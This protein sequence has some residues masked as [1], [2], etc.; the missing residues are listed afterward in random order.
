[1]AGFRNI[2]KSISKGYLRAI[3]S[4]VKLVI[5]AAAISVLGAVIVAPLWY[6]AT[7]HPDVY[8]IL[9]LVGAGGT[10]LAFL[11]YRGITDRS[12]RNHYLRILRK[13]LI[14]LPAAAVFYI[15]ALLYSW[16]MLAAAVPLSAVYVIALGFVLYGKK[17]SA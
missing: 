6:L 17:K 1:M 12:R 11:V 4:L 5:G 8:S 13:V 15:I 14:F 7:R 3:K 9:I 2:A 10:L 16:G